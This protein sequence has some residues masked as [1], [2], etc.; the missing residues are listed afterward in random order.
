MHKNLI[1]GDFFLRV[2]ILDVVDMWKEWWVG[3]W[4]KK[5]IKG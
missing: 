1:P 2:A 3:Y 4:S 5:I